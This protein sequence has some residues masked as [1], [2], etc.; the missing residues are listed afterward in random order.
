M[1]KFITL[2]ETGRNCGPRYYRAPGDEGGFSLIDVVVTVAIIVALSVGGFVSYSGLIDNAKQ[3]AVDYAAS[4][5]YKAALVY[6]SDSSGDTTACSAVDE[7]NSSSGGIRTSLLV[8][9]EGGSMENPLV[10]SGAG[11]ANS[12]SC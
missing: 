7:Y 4:N 9:G 8:A 10:Y 11:E 2:S 5:V 6:E 1:T 3:G 12:Y